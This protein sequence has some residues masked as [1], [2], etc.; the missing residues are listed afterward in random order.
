MKTSYL[1]AAILL[2]SVVGA[3]VSARSAKTVLLLVCAGL[4]GWGLVRLLG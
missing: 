4:S 2:A 1:F 3:L